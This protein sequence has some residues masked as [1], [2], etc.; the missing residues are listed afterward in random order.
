[1]NFPT[2]VAEFKASEISSPIFS[3]GGGRLLWENLFTIMYLS[4]KFDTNQSCLF[5]TPTGRPYN[6]CEWI[7]EL[8]VT[9]ISFNN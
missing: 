6:M 3:G 2:F 5:Q 1:M 7:S 4:A 8:C 9:N